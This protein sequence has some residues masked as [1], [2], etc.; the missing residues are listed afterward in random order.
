MVNVGVSG[1]DG[2]ME[3]IREMRDAIAGDGERERKR[4]DRVREQGK[5]R[6]EKRNYMVSQ[7]QKDRERESERGRESRCETRELTRRS[8][9]RERTLVFND[10]PVSLNI[11]SNYVTALLACIRKHAISILLMHNETFVGTVY[12]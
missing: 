10:S 3:H 4:E 1:R 7:V 11:L 6:E 5:I 2:N 9:D 8:Y 12:E